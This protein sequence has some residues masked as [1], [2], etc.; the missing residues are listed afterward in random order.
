MR[1][2]LRN[3]TRITAVA[4]IAFLGSPAYASTDA[5]TEKGFVQVDGG[6]A[7]WVSLKYLNE[8]PDAVPGISVT[9]SKAHSR[10]VGP[11]SAHPCDD[12]VCMDITGTGL[13]VD[14]WTSTAAG[15]VGCTIATGDWLHG[16]TYG[17]KHSGL[18]CS[19]SSGPGIYYWAHGP[20]GHYPNGTEVCTYWD[21]IS[22]YPCAEI[23]N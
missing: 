5:G 7:G 6:A 8:H 21:E 19:D 14:K 11:A 2:A 13:T 12:Q 9:K 3:L 1:T 20:K 18:I 22:G 23:H 4:A 17:A 16:T 15:N 10:L